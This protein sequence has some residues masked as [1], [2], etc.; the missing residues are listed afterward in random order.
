MKKEEAVDYT[1]DSLTAIHK[2]FGLP[3]PQHPLIT[4]INGSTAGVEISRPSGSHVLKFY[5]IS[6]K[7]KIK[8]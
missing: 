5:K 6:Y 3:E 4:L 8:R 7:T 1:F 2:A